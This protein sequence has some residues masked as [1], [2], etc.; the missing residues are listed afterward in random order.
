MLENPP[1]ISIVTPSYNQVQFLEATIQSV[2]SQNYPN[3]EYIII[4][5]GSTDGSLDII[6]QYQDRLHYWCSEPDAGQYDAINKGFAKSTGD[7]LGWLNSD[8]MYYPW[9]FKTVS[10]IMSELPEVRWLTTLQPGLWDYNGFCHGFLHLPGISKEA[11]LDGCNLPSRIYNTG[12]IQQESTFWTRSLWEEVGGTIPLEFK[13][14]GDFNLWANFFKYTDLY[15]TPSPLAGFRIQEN[16]RSREVK[17]YFTEA[18][19][20]LLKLRK[21]VFWKPNLVRF[22]LFGLRIHRIPKVK[23]LVRSSSLSYKGK[24]ISRKSYDSPKSF[25]TVNEHHFTPY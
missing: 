15:T 17:F 24:V 19:E 4:D 10:S 9:A 3:L 13:L 8:D 7:I 1:K 6:K 20:S 12:F 25:W 22:T 14:A 2:L 18:K 16:Q 23:Y 5:G 21:S 11:F